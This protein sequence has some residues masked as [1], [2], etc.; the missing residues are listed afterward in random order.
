MS[1]SGF[2]PWRYFRIK[3]PVEWTVK[4]SRLGAYLICTK[5]N[6]ETNVPTTLVSQGSNERGG[7]KSKGIVHTGFYSQEGLVFF[8][9]VKWERIAVN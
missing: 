8:L 9:S 5:D 3:I 7:Q 1:L 4:G 6:I 2:G